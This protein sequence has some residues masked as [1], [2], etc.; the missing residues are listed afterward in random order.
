MSNESDV[1]ILEVMA[2]MKGQREDK[3]GIISKYCD[4]VETMQAVI[5]SLH[6][7]E[8]PTCLSMSYTYSVCSLQLVCMYVCV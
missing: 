2:R 6:D 7:S 3:R 4:T 5:K 8:N 1:C